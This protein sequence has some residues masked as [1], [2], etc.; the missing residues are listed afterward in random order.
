[1]ALRVVLVWC[2][3]LV[4][5]SINGIA[6]EA[7]LTPRIGDVGGVPPVPSPLRLHHHSDVVHPRVPSIRRRF[8]TQQEP[9]VLESFHIIE[10]TTLPLARP[11]ST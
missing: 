9:L 4:I 10:T 11:A 2:A 6:R 8:L 7:V 1:M 3:P 5:A